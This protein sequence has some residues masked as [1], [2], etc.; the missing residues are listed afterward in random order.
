[1]PAPPLYNLACCESLTGRRDAALDHLRR[2]I[3]LS[4]VAREYARGDSDFDALRGD[5]AFDELVG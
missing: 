5:P 2:A 4:G 1:V 3:E